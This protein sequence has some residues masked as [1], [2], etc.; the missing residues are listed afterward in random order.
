[1]AGVWSSSSPEFSARALFER[2]GQIQPSV[3]FACSSY[4][5]K[6]KKINVLPLLKEVVQLLPSLRKVIL[7]PYG[8]EQPVVPQGVP[9]AVAYE[10]FV[11][12]SRLLKV[13][14]IDFHQVGFD[15]P[16]YIMFTSGTTGPP[17]VILQGA[18]VLL[19]QL[20]EH[21]LHCDVKRDDVVFYFTSCAWMMWNWLHSALALGCTIVEY[22]GSPLYPSASSLWTMA[23]EE[24]VTI[25]G[26]SAKYLASVEESGFKPHTSGLDL[27][28][29]RTILSTGSPL[30]PNQ[31][32]FIYRDIKP[33][34]HLASISGGT[35]ING[36]LGNPILP[37]YM[38]EL[39]CRGLGMN[40]HVF[41]DNGKPVLDE[42]GELV[43]ISPFP[44]VPLG[45]WGDKNGEK[46]RESYYATFPNIWRHGDFALLSSRTLGIVIYGRSDATLNP[47]GVR[48]GTAEIYRV[49][50]A[51]PGIQDS[52]VVDAEEGV[53]L[54][55]VLK[56][57]KLNEKKIQQ[58]IR[59]S[60]SPRHVPA[61][62]F[63]V[64]DI[65]YTLNGKKAEIAVKQTLLG[66]P[67]KN[68]S[69]LAN[70]Q[71]LSHFLRSRL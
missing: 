4:Y 5:Y 48:I 7:I 64:P 6:G 43:C 16:C 41:D 50:D 32:Q 52:C 14:D 66:V 13:E 62:V 40:V 51:I 55:V 24:R 58:I 11:L 12:E 57:G 67:V 25:F 54:F 22:D 30:L 65:P 21:S 49:V 70:P 45:F 44:S 63:A 35:E 38:G 28:S 69:S 47:G 1:L 42:K 56:E 59:T 27:M 17:K 33:A 39:Q 10:D 68:L 36:C 19:N 61:R 18:G 9:H 31:F 15:H 23:S 46:Y 2:F 53:V 20:K 8:S 60:L 26:T 29:L 71:C 37:V 3:L 34:V